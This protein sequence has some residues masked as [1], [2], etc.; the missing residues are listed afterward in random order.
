M[1]FINKTNVF[2]LFSLLCCVALLAAV[3]ACASPAP[4]A[5]AATATA[6]STELKVGSVVMNPCQL[7]SSD[8]FRV[9]K[10]LCGSVPVYENTVT[11]KGRKI[12]LNVAVI[13]AATPAG[14]AAT[15]AGTAALPT[16]AA[17]TANHSPDPLFLLAG[18]P[19]QAATDAF[20]LLVPDFEG[21]LQ[22]RDIVLVDMRGTG[23]SNPLR[24]SSPN[25]Q[26]APVATPTTAPTPTLAPAE[27]VKACLATLN[28]DPTLY[29]T[30]AAANDLDHVRQALGYQKINLLGVSYGTRLALA[31]LRQYPDRARTLTLDGVSPTDWEL[32]PHNPANAQRSLDLIFAECA[33][34]TAC[35]TAYP[36][37]PQEFAGLMA[38][39]AK[40]PQQVDLVHPLTNQRI[41]LELTQDEAAQAIQFMSFSPDNIAAIPQLIHNV[42]A[43]G[44]YNLLASQYLIASYSLSQPIADG[45]YLSVVC[46]EDV[47][48]YP[49]APGASPVTSYLPDHTHEQAQQ[50]QTWPHATASAAFKQ[51][52]S[53]NAPVLL[54][55]GQLDPVT[56]PAN[57]DQAARTL[58]NSL[59]LVIPGLGH[60]VV[61]AG[62]LPDLVAT[63]VQAGTV[64]GLD[65]SCVKQIQPGPFQTGQ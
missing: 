59:N 37:L 51:P 4:A 62:C 38:G 7:G 10:I 26:A 43:N 48:F 46:A 27:A 36:N 39:L 56:P 45:L 12:L 8:I 57:A 41:R 50:C 22:L 20:A 3:P 64:K 24:C 34:E 42:V 23:K 13:P 29:T 54:L 31:Y 28:A 2:R 47:P 11:Q 53:S 44:Q 58:P 5:T 49:A 14:T 18:G 1:P 40:Q 15:P 6:P 30:Q 9:Y 35:H 33:A 25:L 65:T 60:N 63:F 16:G 19:G 17:V 52:V 21:V 61:F 32:G 55:S